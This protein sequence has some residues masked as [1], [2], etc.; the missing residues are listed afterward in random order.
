MSRMVINVGSAANDGTGDPLRTILQ[1]INSMTS[2]LY[3]TRQRQID[4]NAVVLSES[5]DLYA[6]ESQILTHIASDKTLLLCIYAS[7]KVTETER[8]TSAKALLKIFN[9]QTKA[10]LQTFELFYVGLVAGETIPSE[11]MTAPRM[12]ITGDT[13]RCFAGYKTALYTR[14]IDI[15]NP[16]PTTW[17]LGNI[18]IMKMTMK[19]A[20]GNDVTV[21]VIP[22]NIHT[23]LEYVLGDSYAGYDNLYTFFRNLDR[24]AVSGTGEWYSTIE[25][26]DEMDAGLSNIG[27]L[28]KSTNSGLSWNIV[29]L[30]GYTT[31][32]RVKVIEPS[33]VFIGNNLHVICRTTNSNIFHYSSTDYGAT[34]GSGSAIGLSTLASKPT[35]I[36][37]YE[38]NTKYVLCAVNLTSEWSGDSWRTTLGIYTTSDFVSFTE[39]CKIVTPSYAHYPS[40]CHFSRSLYCSYTKGMLLDTD[41]DTAHQ[42]D[43]NTVVLTRIW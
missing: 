42:H 28:V 3:N 22:A 9:L 19:D 1:N 12:Y 13:L 32:N 37:Y 6:H 40:L 39:I 20:G 7:D 23:H 10:L 31:S 15:S 43:R 38:G 30:I 5:D 25:F 41:G 14:D 16:D 21:D 33:V 35:A 2:E 29:S 8:T 27:A 18:S 4:L 26:S 17:T 36:N 34:W 11:A 24:I